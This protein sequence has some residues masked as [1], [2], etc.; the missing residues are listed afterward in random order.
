MM[1]STSEYM[2][3]TLFAALLLASLP[4]AKGKSLRLLLFHT[5]L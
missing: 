5:G 1:H 3:F 2:A 4:Q